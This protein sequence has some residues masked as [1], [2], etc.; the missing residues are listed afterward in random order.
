MTVTNRSGRTVDLTGWT[1]SDAERHTYRLH[2]KLGAYKSVKV[3][4]GT[5]RDTAADV[6]WNSRAYVWNNDRDTATLRDA[7]G[8]AVASKSWR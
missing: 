1:I 8:R 7:H 5:G 2:L 4:T 3:H 6:Y